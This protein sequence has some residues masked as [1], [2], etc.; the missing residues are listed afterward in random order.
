M[1]DNDIIELYFSRDE[2]AIAETA[3]KYGAYCYTISYNILHD[4][5]D[6]DEC[7]NDTYNKTW[8][9][10]PPTRPGIFKSFLGKI[11]RNLSLDRYDMTNTAKRGGRVAESLDELSECVGDFDIDEKFDSE[12]IATIINR[13]LGEIKE[14]D[15]RI[16]V[17][18]YFFEDSISDIAKMHKVSESQVKTTLFRMRAKLS[19]HLKRE[20]VFV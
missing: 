16:F 20:E 11:T 3:K 10:I 18:R 4:S 12:A 14:L 6:A 5:F 13:F 9:T 7:V 17:R 15:R 19:E 8:H 2:Q 1:Q